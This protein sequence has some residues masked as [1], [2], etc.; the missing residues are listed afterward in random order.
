MVSSVT[1]NVNDACC[2]QHPVGH[3]TR[4]QDSVSRNAHVVTF[5]VIPVIPGKYYPFSNIAPRPSSCGS[6]VIQVFTSG[7]VLRAVLAKLYKVVARFLRI[8]V[9]AAAAAIFLNPNTC[10]M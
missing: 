3:T 6:S 1:C 8:T 9:A 5:C 4:V 7:V 2:K 10:I